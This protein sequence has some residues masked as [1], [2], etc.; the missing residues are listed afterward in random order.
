MQLK[1]VQAGEAVLREHARQLTLDEIH[2]R[3][4]QDLIESMRQTMYQAPGVGLAA[5]QVG[6]GLQVAVIEDKKEY[7]KDAPADFLKERGRKPVPFHVIINPKIT[8]S[9]EAEV[10]FFEGCLSLTGLTAAVPR[11]RAVKLECLDHRGEPKLIQASGWYARILQHEIDHLHGTLYVD[12]MYP[13]SLMTVENFNRTW[14][15]LSI[16]EARNLLQWK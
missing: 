8:L 2:S 11:A 15:A 5:P 10:E 3:E 13:R 9:D 1:I 4:T 6:V 16:A 12:R 14:K 7:M